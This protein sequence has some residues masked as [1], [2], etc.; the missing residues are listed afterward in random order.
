[1]NMKFLYPLC[2]L[3]LLLSC[4]E[5]Q[6]YCVGLYDLGI[7][8]PSDLSMEYV[9]PDQIN[10]SKVIEY[11]SESGQVIKFIP[12]PLDSTTYFAGYRYFEGLCPYDD[13]DTVYYT[14]GKQ[15]LHL[16][17]ISIDSTLRITSFIFVE[18]AP[19]SY[20]DAANY[21][22][23]TMNDDYEIAAHTFFVT[24]Y[25]DTPVEDV[26]PYNNI[27]YEEKTIAGKM[28]NNVYGT[29]AYWS[30]DDLFISKYY[31]VIGFRLRDSLEFRLNH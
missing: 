20:Y 16:E 21:G 30:T 13:T 14:Y 9:N 25:R 6:D 23:H 27:F 11:I 3:M 8:Y 18:A 2:C 12:S 1:M 28:Y 15:P 4:E 31:G 10:P 29:G 7:I 5:E 22:I 26:P 17:L 24:D 19:F